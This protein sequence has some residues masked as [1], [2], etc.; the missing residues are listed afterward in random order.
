MQKQK[1]ETGELKPG[2]TNQGQW[3]EKSEHKCYGRHRGP[4]HPEVVGELRNTPLC[5]PPFDEVE[6][7]IDEGGMKPTAPG[8]LVEKPSQKSPAPHRPPSNSGEL[9]GYL[10]HPRRRRRSEVGA[11]LPEPTVSFQ[12]FSPYDASQGG[13][14]AQGPRPPRQPKRFHS[15]PAARSR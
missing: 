6:F 4:Q 13:A 9:R 15:S 1:G 5:R 11:R 3:N 14:R 7:Q 2:G 10:E 12:R 8:Q